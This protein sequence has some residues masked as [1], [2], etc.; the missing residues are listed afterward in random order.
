MHSFI[1]AVAVAV[2]KRTM[3]V[4]FVS[5]CYFFPLAVCIDLRL[6][7][8]TR[9]AGRHGIE[10]SEE[11]KKNYTKNDKC[12]ARVPL[13][14]NEFSSLLECVVVYFFSVRCVLHPSIHVVFFGF[15]SG[16]CVCV[17]FTPFAAL[18]HIFRFLFRLFCPADIILL[19]TS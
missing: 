7:P 3:C 6:V 8:G 5:F 4:V 13:G 11:W 10:S 19:F 12:S 17:C 18:V 2:S 1:V 16:P 15:N 9:G 14:K